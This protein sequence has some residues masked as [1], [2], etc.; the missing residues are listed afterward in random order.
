ML[1][2]VK[3]AFSSWLKNSPFTQSAAAAYFAVFALPGL[4]IIVMSITTFFLDE[5][6]VRTQIQ[7]YIGN[8][9]GEDLADSVQS[10][11]DR[12]RIKGNGIWTLVIGGSVLLFGASG[13]FN[14]L[15]RSFNSIWG[16]EVRRE[17]SILWAFTNRFV[18]ISVAVML[19]FL[20]LMSMY[21]SAALKLFG[22]WLSAQFPDLEFISALEISA[23]F[24]TISILFTLMF[25]ILPDI[26]IKLRYAFFSGMFCS[27]LFML[28]EIGFT[29]ALEIFSPQSVF[30]AA[31]S[32]VLLML[33]VNYGCMILQLGAEL[34][35]AI[36][37]KHEDDIKTTR[38]VKFNR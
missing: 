5:Q 16:V 6:L 32:I 11:I 25:K 7:N 13:L 2:V 35:K 20:L 9:I 37:L 12:A 18:A 33:W 26:Y 1:E 34:I 28:G 27:F 30:G 15:K 4:L 19:G 31:G 10:I 21:L 8:F 36:M 14:Q 38:F 22:N 17:T 29:K 24:F 23:S 3:D